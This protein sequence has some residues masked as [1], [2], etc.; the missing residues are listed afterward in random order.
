MVLKVVGAGGVM[1]LVGVSDGRDG[2][3]NVVQVVLKVVVV[4]EVSGGGK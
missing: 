1:K 4:L 3:Y 2:G